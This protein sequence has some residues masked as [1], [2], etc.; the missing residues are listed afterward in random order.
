MTEIALNA[1]FY[2]HRPT[3]M[4]RY[5]LE[6]A[7]RFADRIQPLRPARPLR[8][9]TGH[10]WEQLYLPSAVG[11]RL[12][13]SPNNTGPLAV[14]RQVCTIHDLIPLDHPEWFNRRFSAWYEWLLPRLAKKIQHIIAISQFTK[15]R[16]VERLGVRPEKVT[17]IPN[18]VD[19]RF[20]PRTP[21]E[22]EAVRR[23][24][25]INAPA[26][27]LYV[28]SLEPRKNLPRL[29]QAWARV[30]PLLGVEVELVVAGAK[31]NSRVFESARL[32]PLP[33][34]VQFTG[35]VSDEQL[36]CLYS[37]AL[38]LVYP[39]LYEGFGLPPLEAM[40]CGTPVV[41]SNG[42]S[43]PEVAA[44]VAVLVDPEDIDSIAEGIQRVVASSALRDNMRLLGLD[45]ASQT[46]W[47]S[48]AQRTLQ[49]LEEQARS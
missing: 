8:G 46:T 40:A 3:G 26:Y 28:G 12:L 45:R 11:G 33:P 21:E 13:W 42:T 47:D 48:A 10:L 39:S 38:A 36:P 18:G 43:L 7:R 1:R 35:Y 6:L 14:G 5:A 32:D 22:I 15:Q 41:T 19:E 17:V 49:L 20:S 27:L 25:G 44:D 34:R 9:A 23:S 2:A 16:I 30:Q 4:Q 31:G 29:L 37:G 24:L